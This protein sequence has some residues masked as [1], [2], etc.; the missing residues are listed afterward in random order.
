M[1]TLGS[2]VAKAL[3]DSRIIDLPFNPLFLGRFVKK[4]IDYD[5]STTSTA[6]LLH[7][8]KVILY[9]KLF[10]L[11]FFFFVSWLI[12]AFDYLFFIW[13]ST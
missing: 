1:R 11:M 8:I 10:S 5:P 12:L 9:L 3:Y 2:F 6:A 7:D 4:S 13:P